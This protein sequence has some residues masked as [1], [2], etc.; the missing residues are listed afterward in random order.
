MMKKNPQKRANMCSG[1]HSAA[2]IPPTGFGFL[3]K[4]ARAT[5]NSELVGRHFVQTPNEGVFG[6]IWCMANEIEVEGR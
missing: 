3:V 4:V 6:S 5:R 1:S 2:R